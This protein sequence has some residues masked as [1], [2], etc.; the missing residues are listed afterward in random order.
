MTEDDFSGGLGVRLVG[1][2]LE[3]PCVDGMRIRTDA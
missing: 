1:D 3:V 2:G